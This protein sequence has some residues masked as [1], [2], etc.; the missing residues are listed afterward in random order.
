MQ[1]K[2]IIHIKFCHSCLV[3]YYF[4]CLLI[5]SFSLYPSEKT[6]AQGLRDGVLG[7]EG[8]LYNDNDE[9]IRRADIS[10]MQNNIVIMETR[11][12][13][14][15]N[16][17]IELPIDND[18]VAIFSA[19]GYA[20]KRIRFDTRLPDDF[21][22]FN[23]FYFE[24]L[25]ELF[26]A[27]DGVDYSLLEQPFIEISYLNDKEEFFFDE[28]VTKEAVAEV[29]ELKQYTYKAIE[30]IDE[31]NIIIEKADEYFANS[32]FNNAIL[33]Y[34][35]ALKLLSKQKYPKQQ[36]ENILAIME[37]SEELI[38]DY[39]EFVADIEEIHDDYFEAEYEET[40]DVIIEASEKATDD[41]TEVVADV[42]EAP[43]EYIEQEYKETADAVDETT[44]DSIPEHLATEEKDELIEAPK[45]KVADI[46]PDDS[47]VDKEFHYRPTSFEQLQAHFN[48][49]SYKLSDEALIQIDNAI[50][51]LK[52]NPDSNLVISG[53]TDIRG[54]AIFN[55]YL[56]QLRTFEVYNYCI[57]KGVN[58]D[59]M[60]TLAYGQNKPLLL[61]AKS[62]SEHRKNRRVDLEFVDNETIK[63]IVANKPQITYRHLNDLSNEY[64]FSNGVEFMVQF[65]AAKNPVGKS[66]FNMLLQNYPEVNIVYYHDSDK[67]HR[68][69]AGKFNTVDEAVNAA[70]K[71]RSIGYDTYIVAFNNGERLPVS[72]ARNILSENK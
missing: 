16:F 64:S 10:V 61:N 31:Y 57:S 11:T 48:F 38:D 27:V 22:G 55:F 1:F 7:I 28:E 15:G 3:R 25:V 41:F 4:L 35:K 21:S 29:E 62:E 37:P 59:R 49:A 58:P 42:E 65:I 63:S 60:V 44:T 34:E 26:P 23:T 53:H 56:S 45:E 5:L 6:F 24:F 67:F 52:E 46:I 30:Y 18:Y 70:L 43:V 71:M 39:T 68:Y 32:D 19:D 50:K 66:F 8:W 9:P 12:N 36:I 14:R 72:E 2:H 47:I 69:L 20:S 54:N 17:S 51:I 40:A 33:E 13:R